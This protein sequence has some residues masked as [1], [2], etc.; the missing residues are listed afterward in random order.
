MSSTKRKTALI[1][2]FNHNYEKN[3]DIIKKIYNKRFSQLKIIMPFYYGN[4]ADVIGVYGNSFIFHTY[5]TQAKKALMELECDDFLIIGDDLLLHPDITEENIH[6][7]MNIPDGAFYIDKVEN[8]STCQF[9]RPLLEASRFSTRYPG[10]DKSANRYVP[11]YDEAYSI[12]SKKGLISQTSLSVWKPFYPLFEPFNLKNVQK[13][14][15]IFKARVW[16]FLKVIQ[17]RLK[18]VKMP[19]PFVFGYSDILL[20]PREKMTDWTRYLEVFATWNMFVEMAIP[21]AM[22]LLPEATISYAANHSFKTGNVWYPQDPKHFKKI[23]TLIDNLVRS[24]DTIEDFARH[25]PK[26]YLYLHPVKLSRYAN[27]V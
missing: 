18:P 10:L 22:L 21:T 1:V 5:I 3:I 12:L 7:K 14:Y 15:K 20:I 19:Y 2:L 25:Y 9:Q 17:F 16:H 6:E 4:D 24:S 26:E 23:S 8:V 27:Q 11:T 13:N